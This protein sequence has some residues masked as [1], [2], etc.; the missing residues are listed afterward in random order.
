M[1]ALEGLRVLDLT[2]YEAGTSCTQMLAWLG[3]DVVKVERPEIGDPGRH[4]RGDGTDALYFLS[5]NANK[6]SLT[7]DL[8]SEA[9][10]AL[11]LRLLPQ[12]DVVSENFT[13]GTMEKLGLGYEVLKETHPPIIYASGKG[14]GRSGPYKDFKCYD[15]VA[16]AAGGAFSIT[17]F[18]DSEPTRAGPTLGDTGTGLTLALGILAAYIQRQRTGVGQIV[19]VS[20]QEAVLN[21]MRQRLS[22]RERYGDLIPRLGNRTTVPTDLFPCSPGGPNDYVYLMVVTSRMYDALATA[23]DRPDFLTDPRFSEEQGRMEHGDEL[24]EEI[25]CWTRQRTKY[26]VMEELGSAGV[27]C[28]AV[29]DSIDI[30]QDRHLLERGMISTMHHPTRGDW[31]F[32]SPPIRMSDSCVPIAAS[33]LL[34][35]HTEEVLLADLG[36]GADEIDVLRAQGI[37]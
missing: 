3:A 36:M 8:Q 22:T 7:L 26:E 9:G 28:S 12:F 16:Q 5:F 30:F 25:A 20:M 37:V 21:F 14:F 2:Q 15:M 18:P 17:G 29:L 32:P 23:M 33:P 1:P 24:W 31:Q 27:P 19:E 34:G 10:R 4:M 6:R 35:Q 11:F 13:L